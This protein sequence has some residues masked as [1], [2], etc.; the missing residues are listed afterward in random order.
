MFMGFKTIAVQLP[1]AENDVI[2]SYALTKSY[3]WKTVTHLIFD[4]HNTSF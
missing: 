1:F 3:L 2:S 4:V